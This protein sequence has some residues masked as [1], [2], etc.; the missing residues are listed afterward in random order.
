[1][2]LLHV[3]E[4]DVKGHQSSGAHVVKEYVR[5]GAGH[6]VPPPDQLRPAPLLMETMLYLVR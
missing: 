5:A 6:E 2:K 1:M 4:K 3:L